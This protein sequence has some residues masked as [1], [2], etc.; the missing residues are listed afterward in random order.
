MLDILENNKFYIYV[1]KNGKLKLELY[2]A[3]QSHARFGSV[4][5]AA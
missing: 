5:L 3:A 2:P 4:P 1:V